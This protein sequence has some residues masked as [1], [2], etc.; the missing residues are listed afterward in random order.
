MSETREA[1]REICDTI[2]KRVDRAYVAD[3]GKKNILPEKLWQMWIDTGLLAMGLPE[4]YG[5]AGGSLGDIV[6]AL[7][8]LHREALLLPLA[9]PNFMSREPLLR[10]GSEEQ[11]RR[12]LPPTATGEEFFSFGITEPDSGTNTFKIKT[13]AIRQPDG[14]FLVNGQKT[15]QTAFKES[16]H[17]LLVARTS[18]YRSENRKEGISLFIV[19]TK[20]PGIDTTQMEIGM[21]L[22]E[23]NYQVYYDNVVLTPDALVGEEGR[24]LQILFDS[25]NPER[26][27]VGAMNLGQAD[28]VLNR[29]V[30]YAKIRAPFDTPIG[31]YQSIQHPMARAKTYIESARNMLYLAADKHDRGEQIGLEANMVKILSSEAFKM[32]A[33]IAMTAFGGAGFRQRLQQRVVDEREA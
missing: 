9:V 10:H 22:P 16:A 26:L 30:E 11:K 24:G 4:E 21:Y 29:A 19:D 6:Y 1:V 18:P 17:C 23:K 31:A 12:Y 7:D 8:L 2:I 27:L 3:C 25:L 5:G 28:Y 13:T 14:T 15:Y 32:A 20:L 33:E